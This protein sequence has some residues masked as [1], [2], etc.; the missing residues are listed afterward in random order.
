MVFRGNPCNR[1]GGAMALI[2]GL[3]MGKTGAVFRDRA[4]HGN[5]LPGIIKDT[6]VL[7]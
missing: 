5:D 6:Q 7:A 2:P 4:G 3:K 1:I